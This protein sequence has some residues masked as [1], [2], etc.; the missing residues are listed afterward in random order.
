MALD[1]A[2]VGES[3]THSG[4]F[5]GVVINLYFS[6]NIDGISPMRSPVISGY[7]TMSKRQKITVKFSTLPGIRSFCGAW[8]GLKWGV[9][10]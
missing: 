6:L 5:P 4:R 1:R 8:H 9:N 7:T 3:W 10:A 2:F